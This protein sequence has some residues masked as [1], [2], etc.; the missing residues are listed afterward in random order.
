MSG[1]FNICLPSLCAT[2]W[3]YTSRTESAIKELQEN[4]KIAIQNTLVI[5]EK[6][7][8]G[9][10]CKT[11]HLFA[12]LNNFTFMVSRNCFHTKP[13]QAEKLFDII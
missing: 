5:N 7:D 2:R 9:T 4:L 6:W 12:K 1:D 11:D 8:E 13:S 10:L 3:C